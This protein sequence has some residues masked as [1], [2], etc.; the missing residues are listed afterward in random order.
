MFRRRSL[1]TM[2]GDLDLRKYIGG[3]V[4]ALTDDIVILIK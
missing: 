1:D 4:K 2:M 3:L